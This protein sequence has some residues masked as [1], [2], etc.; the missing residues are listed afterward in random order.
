MHA[1][2]DLG[3]DY[4]LAE[5]GIIRSKLTRRGLSF[6]DVPRVPAGPCALRLRQVFGLSSVAANRA[7]EL[8]AYVWL[9]PSRSCYASLVHKGR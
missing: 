5:R 1:Y 2:M 3:D 8:E 4:V 9:V 6:F 7:S